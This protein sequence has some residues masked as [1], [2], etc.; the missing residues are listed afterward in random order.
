MAIILKYDGAE[1]IDIDNILSPD[2]SLQ[3]TLKKDVC[4]SG[5]GLHSGKKTTITIHPADENTGIVFSD[6]SHTVRALAS[7][8][9]DTSRGTTIGEYST[10][11]LTIEHLM[12][13]L[14]GRGIDNAFVE[15]IGP[16][17]PALD[18][19]SRLYIKAIDEVGLVEQAELRKTIVLNEPIWVQASDSYIL[20]TPYDGLRLT[21]VMN[22]KHPLIGAQTSTYILNENNFSSEIA[23]AR[24]FALYEEVAALLENHLAQGGSIDNAVVLWQDHTSTELRFKDELVRHKILDLIGDLSLSGGLLQADVVAVKSGHRLNVEFAKIVEKLLDEKNS[25]KCGVAL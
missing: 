4:L 9:I 19:S 20:A 22:Y 13:A 16:E 11:L 5:I 12:A 1:K 23:P 24:T 7:K 8:V 21:Y 17:T 15:I 10:R 6:G 25:S 14:R 18:G 2:S 3:K